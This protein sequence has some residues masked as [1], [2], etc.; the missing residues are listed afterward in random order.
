MAPLFIFACVKTRLRTREKLHISW[1]SARATKNDSFRARLVAFIWSK[2]RDRNLLSSWEPI[3]LLLLV[4]PCNV[5]EFSRERVVCL[6]LVGTLFIF[7]SI[8]TAYLAPKEQKNSCFTSTHAAQWC[9]CK[10]GQHWL[11]F[12]IVFFQTLSLK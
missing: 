5:S 9:Q 12:L 8:S 4:R 7:N 1:H 2:T 3:A 10:N 11:P 6:R